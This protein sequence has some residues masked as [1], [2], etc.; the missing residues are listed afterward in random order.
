MTAILAV[1]IGMIIGYFGCRFLMYLLG[2]GLG[3]IV[4]CLLVVLVYTS[5]PFAEAAET[6][7]PPPAYNLVLFFHVGPM[8]DGN[9]NAVTYIPYATEAGCEQAGRLA[10]RLVS[11]TVKSLNYICL[12]AQ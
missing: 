1:L 6:V 2:T 4:F 3:F 5:T 12:P 8:G 7:T 11:G 9:S 10:G